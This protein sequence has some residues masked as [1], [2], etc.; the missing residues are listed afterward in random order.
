M[1]KEASLER[2][3]KQS[4]KKNPEPVGVLSEFYQLSRSSE[5]VDRVIHEHTYFVTADVVLAGFLRHAQDRA[6]QFHAQVFGRATLHDVLELVEDLALGPAFAGGRGDVVTAHIGEVVAKTR[7]AESAEVQAVAQLPAA[8]VFSIE[9][10]PVRVGQ[11]DGVATV[12]DTTLVFLIAAVGVAQVA[13]AS[14]ALVSNGERVREIGRA[15]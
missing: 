12:A 5:D 8:F 10:G 13:V 3:Y 4:A 6:A 14:A 1:P 9:V 11:V 2:F 7:N 15:S